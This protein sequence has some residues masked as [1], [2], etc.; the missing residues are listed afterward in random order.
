MQ[1]VNAGIA[2]LLSE[3]S[4]RPGRMRGSTGRGRVHA[5]FSGAGE[6]LLP[7]IPGH[8]L[9]GCP[10]TFQANWLQTDRPPRLGDS[11][12]ENER[13]DAVFPRDGYRTGC[14][15]A[16]HDNAEA[17]S[18]VE[19]S[20][21]LCV[22]DLPRGLDDPEDRRRL[23]E[24]I[25][26]EPNVGR[27]AEQVEQA[28]AG[29]V[30]ERPDCQFRKHRQDRRDVNAGWHEQFL[31]ERPLERCY[32]VVDGV[33]GLAKEDRAREGQTVAVDAAAGQSHHGIAGMEIL[34]DDHPVERNDP[35]GSAN[36]VETVLALSP[37][38]LPDLGD[39]AAR[40]RHARLA[41]ALVQPLAQLG[42]YRRLQY[43]HRHVINQ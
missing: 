3:G 29:H 26:N 30:D 19:D 14:L 17:D 18:H 38:H 4:R 39:L 1:T 15:L 42:Q 36:E 31:A 20:E 41:G 27:D 28:V 13:L 37:D 24:V 35:N 7:A 9:E 34:T 40:D 6:S 5:E 23:G 8:A 43:L 12:A 16:W 22:W 25:N 10:P 21:H 2:D 32:P 33:A 11:A